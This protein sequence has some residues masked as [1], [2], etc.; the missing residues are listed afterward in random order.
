MAG[1]A[2]FGKKWH[3]IRR[4]SAGRWEHGE[5]IEGTD[6]LV[7]IYANIQPAFSMQQTRLLP[8][9]DRDKEAIWGSSNH[10]VYKAESGDP[11]ISPDIVMYRGAEWEVKGVMPYLNHGSHVEFVA[12]KIKDSE[13]PRIGG[14]VNPVPSD[15]PITPPTP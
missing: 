6:E 5:W 1:V 14:I 11:P 2:K 13:A 8:E 15:P 4:K 3:N 9:G 10:W 12:V 7:K